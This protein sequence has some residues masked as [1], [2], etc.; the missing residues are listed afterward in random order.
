MQGLATAAKHVS[1]TTE[2]KWIQ[3]VCIIREE[4]V[5]YRANIEKLFTL[6]FTTKVSHQ[7]TYMPNVRTC[8]LHTE[9]LLSSRGLKCCQ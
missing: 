8:K 5:N 7:F 4:L 2:K 3:L 1:M 6:T 9:K